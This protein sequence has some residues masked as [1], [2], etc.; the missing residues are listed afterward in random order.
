V[1]L[2]EQ[3]LENRFPRLFGISLHKESMVCEVGRW[4]NGVWMWVLE[5][6]RHLFVWEEE[7]F[8]ELLEVLARVVI[9]DANDRWI[10]K[11]GNEGV[12][13]VKSTYV[14]LDHM[15][16]TRVPRSTLDLFA[17]KFI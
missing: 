5:W 2:G 6:W 7:L 14:F 8:Q 12:H 11:A 1:W 9:I 3:S 4:E 17:F 15:F 16:N 10:W 13:T